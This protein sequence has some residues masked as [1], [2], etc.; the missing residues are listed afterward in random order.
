ML[1]QNSK[2]SKILLTTPDYPPKLGG[3][4]TY[5]KSIE[6]SLSRLGLEYD[7]LVWEGAA[8]LKNFQVPHQ[9][10]FSLH[11]HFFGNHYL[12]SASKYHINF[13]HGS[14]ILFTSPNLIKKWLKFALKP[15]FLRTL[16]NSRHNIFISE[17]TQEKLSSLGLKPNF[18]RDIVFHNCIDLQKANKN[19]QNYEDGPLRLISLA[20]D[21]PH[22]NLNYCYEVAKHL[23]KVTFRNVELYISKSFPSTDLVK[24]VNI[25]GVSDD[26]RNELL[27]NSHF[28][29]LLSLDHSY[30]GFYEGF[31]LTVLEAASFGTP[32]IVSPYG[33]LPEACHHGKT[34][35]VLPLSLKAFE[36]FFRELDAHTY[37]E[38]SFQSYTHA[39]QSH[40]DEQYDRL[41]GLFFSGDL[42]EP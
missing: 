35:W 8:S 15:L 32:S 21:V 6:R 31:G 42:I 11:I 2:N 33:G 10:D 27:A 4:S 16:K 29:L 14:E 40:N 37:K 38:V 28:N 30:R 19:I 18:S 7:V 22:K 9:Y 17:F 12:K 25:S 1:H 34:G 36:K 26:E 5:S 20:R 41:L 13:I 3:L 24:T 23:A 39:L